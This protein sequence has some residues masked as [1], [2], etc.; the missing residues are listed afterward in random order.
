MKYTEAPELQAL[1]EKIMNERPEMKELLNAHIKYVWG[2]KD[3]K[4]GNGWVYGQCHKIPEKERVVTS[5][6][7]IITFFDRAHLLSPAAQKLL[8]LH[9]LKH[10]GF[11]AETG[12]T[13]INDHDLQD[14]K[15]IV[16][17]NGIDWI[18]R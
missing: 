6:H 2:N 13:W 8:M 4:K 18:E 16:E 11:D 12:K 9:E 10:A 1:A 15:E 3:K 5:Y 7:F 17:K 14:F